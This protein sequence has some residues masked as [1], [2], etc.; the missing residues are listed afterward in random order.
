M[1]NINE[2]DKIINIGIN[3]LNLYD[4]VYFSS[5]SNL[6]E[7]IKSQE[8]I[9]RL[10]NSVVEAVLNLTPEDPIW[11]R[12]R[13]ASYFLKDADDMVQQGNESVLN[14]KN[15]SIDEIRKSLLDSILSY[16]QYIIY[17]GIF[18]L[19]QIDEGNLT[20]KL[21]EEHIKKQYPDATPEQIEKTINL[22]LDYIDELE[23]MEL[24]DAVMDIDYTKTGKDTMEF[25][26]DDDDYYVDTVMDDD[27][28][29]LNWLK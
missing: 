25:V 17:I 12:V 5:E 28:T 9:P 29:N 26:D 8:L 14:I 21:S 19:L 6:L 27:Q 23:E 3:Y 11:E 13:S 10:H 16:E 20:L 4:A 2:L 15:M 7:T 18:N 1:N 24:T 22:Y